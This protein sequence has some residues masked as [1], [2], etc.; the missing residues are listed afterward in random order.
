MNVEKVNISGNPSNGIPN[1][2]C[3]LSPAREQTKQNNEPKTHNRN[4]Y[5]NIWP[6]TKPPFI[7]LPS[8]MAITTAYLYDC[9]GWLSVLGYASS[10]VKMWVEIV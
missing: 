3:C 2:C 6:N 10:V 4:L 7:S 1:I 8:S 5:D 9:A